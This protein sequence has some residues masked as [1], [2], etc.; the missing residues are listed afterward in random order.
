MY[1]IEKSA[2]Q[3]A[4]NYIE[5]HAGD[6]TDR[7]IAAFV[8]GKHGE[9]LLFLFGQIFSGDCLFVCQDTT[10]NKVLIVRPNT[11]RVSRYRL[12]KLAFLH[13]TELA[14]RCTFVISEKAETNCLF[15]VPTNLFKRLVYAWLGASGGHL[16]CQR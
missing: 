3:S 2:W 1:S 15:T 13:L 9:K 14:M 12:W 11:R 6:N 7:L 10:N 4:L 5:G 16:P 8:N